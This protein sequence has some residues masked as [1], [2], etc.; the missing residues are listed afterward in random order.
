M[1][2]RPSSALNLAVLLCFL[3]ECRHIQYGREVGCFFRLA[4][5]TL[6]LQN[7]QM[8]GRMKQ[9]PKDYKIPLSLWSCSTLNGFLHLENF[10]SWKRAGPCILAHCQ[11]SWSPWLRFLFVSVKLT[12]IGSFY[13]C[14]EVPYDQGTIIFELRGRMLFAWSY[15]T[16]ARQIRFQ[17]DI[18]CLEEDW[19][20]RSHCPWLRALYLTQDRSRH[21][22][23][24]NK[25]RVHM[26]AR[27]SRD[28][29]VPLLY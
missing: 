20:L 13:P 10:Q 1:D 14:A 11:T 19:Y 17:F 8:S 12:S 23:S 15:P 9:H 18:S 6:L 26:A 4:W 5:L 29:I 7:F 22:L 28:R 21:R 3:N 27:S 24:Y 25:D 2:W 16:K